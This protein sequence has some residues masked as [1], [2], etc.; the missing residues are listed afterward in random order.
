VPNARREGTVGLRAH[1]AVLFRANRD[2]VILL[3]VAVA[4]RLTFWLVTDRVGEDALITV[5]HA[6]IAVSGIGLTHHPGEPVT[7]GFTSAVSVL[8]PLAGEVVVRGSGIFVLRAASLV[9][10]AISMVLA[11]RICRRLGLGRWP[12]ILALAYL[13]LDQNQIFY[14]MAGMETQIAVMV[15]LWSVDAL[16]TGRPIRIGLTFGVA[17]LTRPDFL[18]WV[19]AGSLDLVARRWT[20]AVK[21]LAVAALVIAPWVLFTTL[22]YYGRAVSPG[23]DRVEPARLDRVRPRWASSD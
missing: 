1:L 11:A 15:L 2:V 21:A 18:L 14:G 5:T 22:Y 7:H 13:A 9:A 20:S 16:M 10:V 3:G 12:T 8:V 17:I 4:V 6:R 19:C 23:R